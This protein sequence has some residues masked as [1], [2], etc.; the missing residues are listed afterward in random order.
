MAEA[1]I[2]WPEYEAN[3]R[4]LLVPGFPYAIVYKV[5]PQQIVIV[6]LTHTSRR[7]A[8]WNER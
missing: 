4:R 8:Y 5:L 6:A 3:T 1:P 7:P 2:R